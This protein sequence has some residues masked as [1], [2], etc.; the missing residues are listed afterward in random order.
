MDGRG[1]TG[2]GRTTL[3]MLEG[4]NSA[5]QC[6]WH[7]STPDEFCTLYPCACTGCYPSTYALLELWF[8]VCLYCNVHAHDCYCHALPAC[9]VAVMCISPQIA[10]WTRNSREGPLPSNKSH[11]SRPRPPCAC[12]RPACVPP[13]PCLHYCALCCVCA[14]I[15]ADKNM[16]WLARVQFSCYVTC[17]GSALLLRLHALSK[18]SRPASRGGS[19]LR[20]DLATPVRPKGS[21]PA[22][23]FHNDHLTL[24]DYP[25]LIQ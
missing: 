4:H 25:P 18:P 24:A 11:E 6:P 2:S 12:T 9:T 17:A 20:Q 19:P 5:A 10:G 16:K 14:C 23:S 15:V 22:L 3:D 7:S 8:A 1:P 13:A 21:P